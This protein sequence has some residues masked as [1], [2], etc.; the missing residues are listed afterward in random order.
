M[1]GPADPQFHVFVDPG[2]P[3]GAQSLA[4]RDQRPLPDELDRGRARGRR[5]A[6]PNPVLEPRVPGDGTGAQRLRDVLRGTQLGRSSARSCCRPAST[7]PGQPARG[8]DRQRAGSVLQP[9][10]R[11]SAGRSN[12]PGRPGLNVSYQELIRLAFKRELWHNETHR[13]NGSAAPCSV[14]RP[15]PVNGE[16]TPPGCDPFDGYVLS[17]CRGPGEPDRTRTSSPR[18]RRTSASSSGLSLQIWQELLIP[19]DTPFDRFMDA[20]PLAAQRRRAARRARARCLQPMCPGSS[21]P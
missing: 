9:A 18:W 11:P 6:G 20:N 10:H 15:T 12:R 2:P 17:R 1:F 19:D 14:R 3:G 21:A 7:P 8:P 16:L 5:A 4:G 13:L